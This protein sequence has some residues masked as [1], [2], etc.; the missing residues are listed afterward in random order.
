MAGSSH[1]LKKKKNF[2]IIV[3]LQGSPT[4]L[5]LRGSG[6]VGPLG[7]P[8]LSEGPW[9]LTVQGPRAA[10]G[11]TWPHANSLCSTQHDVPSP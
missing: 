4:S 1:L 5:P 6:S 10:S 11:I 8:L 3:D 2:G 7:Y 9:L